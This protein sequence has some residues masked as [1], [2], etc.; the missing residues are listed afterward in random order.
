MM[1]K[2]KHN[3]ILL[4]DGSVA[5]ITTHNVFR[6][7]IRILKGKDPKS[8]TM[9]VPIKKYTNT[10][11]DKLSELLRRNTHLEEDDIII[12]INHIRPNTIEK[13]LKELETSKYYVNANSKKDINLLRTSK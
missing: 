11:Y 2:K 9:Y 8:V 12:L 13:S 3:Y 1:L 4:E 7:F 6:E 5:R 10:E